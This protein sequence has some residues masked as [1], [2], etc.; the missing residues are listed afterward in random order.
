ME[1]L[2]TVLRETGLQLIAKNYLAPLKPTRTIAVGDLPI[3]PELKHALS[4]KG[5]TH[6]SDFQWESYRSIAG[7]H[8]T[9]I[10]AG[11]GSG[12]T[13]AWLLPVLN[14]LSGHAGRVGCVVLYPTKALARDQLERIK[15]ICDPLGL[16]VAVY[17]GDTPRD[18]RSKILSD[19]P[20][21]L[22]TNP[23]MLN[24]ATRN[25]S[26]RAMM[27]GI[28]YLV[29]D[30]FHVYQ[31][32]FGA[33]MAWLVWRL[34]RLLDKSPVFI[35]AT[36]TIS[37]P[38]LLFER[39]FGAQCE[40]IR[41]D[42]RM[43][44][45]LHLLVGLGVGRAK[46][47]AAARLFEALVS[48]SRRTILFVDSHL[49]A[50]LL[51]RAVRAKL[52]SKVSIHRAGLT[53]DQRETVE[54]ALREGKIMG[55]IATPTLE[56]GLDVGE[57]DT[58]INYGVTSSHS[59]YVQRAGRAGRRGNLGVII[60]LLGEDP[61]SRY[62]KQ[63]P[64]EF[65]GRQLEPVFLDPDNA[66]IAGFHLLASTVERPLRP[67][68][69]RRGG[70]TRA[71]GSLVD[72]KLVAQHRGYYRCTAAGYAYLKEW[73]GL[74]SS[75]DAVAIVLEDGR[76]LGERELPIAVAEL[77]PHAVYSHMGVSY[78]ITKFDLDKKLAYGR[79][80]HLDN[81]FTKSLSQ[82]VP[83]SF[84]AERSNMVGQVTIQH[85]RL[86]LQL[87]V[88]GYVVRDLDDNVLAERIL[89]EPLNY[90]FETKALR[91]NLPPHPDWSLEENAEAFHALEHTLI[92]A[93]SITTG[94]SDVDLGGISTPHG[95]VYIYDGQ[96]GGSGASQELLSRFENTLRVADTILGECDC[97][98]GCPK[99]VY[100]VHCGNNNKY[101]SRRRGH[102][103]SRGWLGQLGSE[104]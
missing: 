35:G 50:E 91:F 68:E 11:T 82:R 32:V 30:D 27:S 12:K 48:A 85:G 52:G 59:R 28:D 71:F 38:Q 79:R 73:R 80:I 29:L 25:P 103:L 98:D 90:V 41:S 24:L 9:A 93:S 61:I 55:V 49:G 14:G 104:T 67:I 86:V 94:L 46:R 34:R 102:T 66:E 5:I 100:T 58:V 60:Q 33:N 69:I 42:S 65:F 20:D 3:R 89:D 37:E 16:S 87:S 88:T 96:I 84:D 95:E 39:I 63:R 4:L 56:L 97:D 64:A 76:K 74:R 8:N 72:R 21:V 47:V 15:A 31:G 45:Q 10:V 23:D 78:L 7:G 13:E 18:Q 51:Y 2:N 22:V 101:L 70:P 40:V 62:Y 19:P 43:S 54:E 53:A 17:H 36:A 75:G 99:C 77:H 57:L 83:R 44:G 81:I 26:F 92:S 1:Q 6:L